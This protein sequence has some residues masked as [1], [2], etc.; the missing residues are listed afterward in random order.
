MIYKYLCTETDKLSQKFMDGAKT[1]DQWQKIR[2]R[3]Y[4]EYM[5]MLGLWPLPEKTPLK[6]T[7]TGQVE[8]HGVIVEKLHFQ[9][10]PGL[11]VTA[12][13]YRPKETDKPL[14]TILYL[15]GHS[16]TKIAGVSYGAKTTYQHHAAWFAR[17]GYCHHPGQ[18]R[19]GEH[20]LQ[21]Q[22]QWAARPS[23]CVSGTR[24]SGRL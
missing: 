15:C 4:Q 23:D 21:R 16:N 6:A 13:F 19:P 7:V 1:L 22:L 11:Y 12:N 10:K 20:Y 2:P 8:A 14:P 18:L 17:H 24:G 5:D 9:S 3:L